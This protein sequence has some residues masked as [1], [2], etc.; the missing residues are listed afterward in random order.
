VLSW[1]ASTDN[2]AVTSYEVQRDGTSLGV[3]SSTNLTIVGLSTGVTYAMSVRAG[4][5]AGNW[6][7]WSSPLNVT[8]TSGSSGITS[9]NYASRTA[10]TV[11]LMWNPAEANSAL[12]GYR[13]S[14][15]GQ[16]VGTTMDSAYF[17]SGLAAGT[18]YSYTITAVDSMGNLIPGSVSLSVT[19]TQDFSTDTDHDGV[20]DAVE[21]L[22]N[23]NANAAA[24]PDSTNQL[25]VNIQRPPK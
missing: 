10:T 13:V 9:L 17:D 21:A 18:T 20:P 1:N 22:L 19:T 2:A 5:A 4:D 6:S 11:T 25:Q 3:G 7:A 24:T 23:T 15:N 16:L 12:G 8:L 14:R